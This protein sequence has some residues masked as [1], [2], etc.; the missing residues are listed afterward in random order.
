LPSKCPALSFAFPSPVHRAT[1]PLVIGACP[2]QGAANVTA[3][4]TTSQSQAG[5]K[6][7]G[8]FLVMALTNL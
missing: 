1:S 3:H 5:A 2:K 6:K 8:V 7:G 4:K